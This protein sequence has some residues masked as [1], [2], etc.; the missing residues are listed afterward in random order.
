MDNGLGV[1]TKFYCFFFFF[2]V[3]ADS[4]LCAFNITGLSGEISSNSSGNH[5]KCSWLITTARDHNI[6]LRFTTFQFSNLPS[7]GVQ[8]L[9]HVYN[10]N[11]TNAT[12][13]GIFTGTRKPFIVHSSGRFM[14]IKLSVQE[15]YLHAIHNFKATYTSTTG[16]GKLHSFI[17]LGIS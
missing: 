7:I 14:L 6:R 5:K 15:S 13:T 1:C 12:L 8:S 4:N 2:L 3:Y 11:N 9:I 17:V 10:G 16:I